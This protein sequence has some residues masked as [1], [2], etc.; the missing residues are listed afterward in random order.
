MLVPHSHTIRLI[1][2]A[3]L[4]IS[5]KRI[6]SCVDLGTGS[7]IIA[8]SLKKFFPDL[9]IQATDVSVNA[10]SLAQMN[11]KKNKVEI[12]FIK[13]KESFFWLKEFITKPELI[14]SNP[15]YMSDD[16]YFSQ[17]MRVLYPEILLEPQTS[18]RSFDKTGERY[19]KQIIEEFFLFTSKYLI[20][21]LTPELV[22]FVEKILTTVKE[23]LIWEFF[24]SD[25]RKKRFVII[26]KIP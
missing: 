25:D 1:Q 10:L 13:I 4:F 14:I 23:N 26:E 19:F 15:P 20:F 21:E 24:L 3:A 17:E 18:I 12:D 22:P 9:S 6:T 2:L 5:K 16:E 8:I 7:G 11:A